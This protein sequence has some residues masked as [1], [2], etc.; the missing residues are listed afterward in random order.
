MTS[1]LPSGGTWGRR[2]ASSQTP[3]LRREK[4]AREGVGQVSAFPLD[5]QDDTSGAREAA[6][7]N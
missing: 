5:V 7:S 4:E 6:I 3:E 1:R 2:L